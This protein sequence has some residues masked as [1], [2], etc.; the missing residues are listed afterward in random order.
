MRCYNCSAFGHKSQAC[1]SLRRQPMKSPSYTSSIKFNEPRMKSNAIKFEVQKTSYHN[2]GHS[3]V[4]MK[5]NVLNEVDQC[6]EDVFHMEG[7]D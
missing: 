5:N 3:Q 2:Q 4:W 1:A 6:I 7:Q